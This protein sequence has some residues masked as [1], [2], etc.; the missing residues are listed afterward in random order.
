MRVL[1]PSLRRNVGD[2]ALQDLE[3]G[4]LDTLARDVPGD[5]W[6]LPLA[7]DLVH[8]VDV[9]DASFRLFLVVA[10]GLIQL[11][12]DVLDV[13]SHVAGLGQGRRVHDRERHREKLGQ[14]LG[15]KGLTRAGRADQQDVGL[16]EL[17]VQLPVLLQVIDALVVVVDRHR[18][19]LLGLVLT[20]H[21]PVEELLDLLGLGK[22]RLRGLG[23]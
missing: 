5:R 18:E 9:D 23:L 6:V 3:Q 1:A 4:L 17:D 14:G 16:L 2:R 22:L 10:G 7:G 15:E 8:L 20:D 12:D 11:Q 19:L 21:V 13:L